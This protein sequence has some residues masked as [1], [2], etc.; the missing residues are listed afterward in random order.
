MKFI[1][2][3]SSAILTIGLVKCFEALFTIEWSFPY[4]NNPQDG[5]ASAVFGMPLPYTRWSQASS[6]EFNFM[7]HIYILNLFILFLLFYPLVRLLMKQVL[8]SKENKLKSLVAYIGIGL[9]LLSF[10]LKAP[11]YLHYNL[12]FSILN[13]LTERYS[14]IRP[15]KFIFN[16]GHYECSP[17]EYWFSNI[18]K[19]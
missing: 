10:I 9:T 18:R 8:S 13:P 16:D 17:S 14:E 7:P 3:H 12:E 4:C 11:H 2:R 1:N 19:Q 5:M 6:L 15:I